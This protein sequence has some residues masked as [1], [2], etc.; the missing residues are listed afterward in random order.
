MRAN[1]FWAQQKTKRF[2][3]LRRDEDAHF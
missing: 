1:F 3:F 2:N